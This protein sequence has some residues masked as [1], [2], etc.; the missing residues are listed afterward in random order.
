MGETKQICNLLIDRVFLPRLKNPC[1]HFEKMSSALINGM[2]AMNPILESNVFV[3]YLEMVLQNDGDVHGKEDF[4]K[5]KWPDRFKLRF[6]LYTLWSL[7]FD[8]VRVFHNYLQI[9]TLWL[10]RNYPFLAYY[11]FGKANSCVL[12]K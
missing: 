8:L 11:K 6:I 5:L 3:L 10:M 1:G 2:W 7:Q 9:V 12:V 4:Q